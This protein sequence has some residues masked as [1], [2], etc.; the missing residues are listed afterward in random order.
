MGAAKPDSYNCRS[1]LPPPPRLWRTG[2]RNLGVAA[3]FAAS[4]EPDAA[5]LR[6]RLSKQNSSLNGS[7]ILVWQRED[8]VRHAAT[9]F[10]L[11][12]IE[13]SLTCE[14]IFLSHDLSPP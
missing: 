5:P 2:A 6:Q 9:A 3:R 13:I 1:E 10:D 8:E 14:S 7:A 12:P 4:S 11:A